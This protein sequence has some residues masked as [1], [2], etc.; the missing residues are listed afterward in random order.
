MICAYSEEKKI[1]DG[2]HRMKMPYNLFKILLIFTLIFPGLILAEVSSEKQGDSSL[3]SLLP[4]VDSWKQTE[5]PQNYLPGNLFEYIN[6][7]AEIYLAYDFQELIVS[8]YKIAKGEATIAVEIY[9]MIEGKNSFGIYSAERFP[10][11]QFISLGIQGYLEEGVLNF[12][13]GRYYVKLLCFDCEEQSDD[14]LKLFSQEIVKRVEDKGDFPR[15]LKAFPDEGRSPNTEKFILRN[16]MGYGFLH[17]GYMVN[18]KLE[19]L[20]FDCFLIE[21]KSEA[22]AQN[23]LEKYLAAKSKE[24]IEETSFGYRLKDR[25]YQNIFLAKAKNYICGVLKIKD[26]AEKVGE[27]YLK[28]LVNSLT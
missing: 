3:L 21:G 6:G 25:Y 8:Q 28:A 19:G 9:D 22:D 27:R 24:G 11:S 20:E 16:F 2:E 13:V 7:A 5:K 26:G 10:E 18:Y 15:L 23:M 12:L 14:V 1:M 17:D 4:E